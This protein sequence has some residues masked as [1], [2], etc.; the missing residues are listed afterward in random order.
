MDTIAAKMAFKINLYPNYTKYSIYT[1]YLG[2]IHILSI[3]AIF[4]TILSI[5]SIYCQVILMDA[6]VATGAAA[7]MAIRIHIDHTIYLS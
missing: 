2:I 5:I 6:T 1:Y 4:I 7:M 3:L